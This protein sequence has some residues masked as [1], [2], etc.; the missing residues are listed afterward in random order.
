M[1]HNLK[2]FTIQRLSHKSDFLVAFTILITTWP[3]IFSLFAVVFSDRFVF[4]SF[5]GDETH[6]LA[7]AKQYWLGHSPVSLVSGVNGNQDGFGNAAES[8]FYPLGHIFNHSNRSFAIAAILIALSSTVFAV[9]TFYQLLI[10]LQLSKSLAALGVSLVC[11]FSEF[12][13]SPNTHSDLTFSIARWPAPSLHYVL[14]N[15]VLILLL[16]K[17][18]NKNSLQIGATL[19]VGFYLYFFTWQVILA[20]VF[21]QLLISLYRKEWKYSYNLVLGTLIAVLLASPIILKLARTLQTSTSSVNDFFI[22][23][24]GYRE[25]RVFNL[26]NI[27]ILLGGFIFLSFLARNKQFYS[28]EQKQILNTILLSSLII[29]SQSLITGREIQPGHYYWYFEKPYAILGIYILIARFIRHFESFVLSILIVTL[30][31]ASIAIGYQA[32]E[33]ANKID[34][35]PSIGFLNT[36]GNHAFTFSKSISGYWAVTSSTSPMPILHM[37]YYPDSLTETV[38]FCAAE[39]IW[40]SDINLDGGGLNFESCSVSPQL[41]GFYRDK[42]KFR[43]KVEVAIGGDVSF[44]FQ[45]WLMEYKVDTLVLDS[46]MT[47]MQLKILSDNDFAYIGKHGVLYSIY[48]RSRI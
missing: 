23:T 36:L 32:K 9:I 29:Q 1:A 22:F 14:I 18:S 39:T 38:R 31:L 40:S 24:L 45:S 46:P 37:V 7:R 21:A 3:W 11:I 12:I 48:K 8:I 13:L 30:L 25:I 43:S 20:I 5:G 16:G 15:L 35:L 44:F 34:S 27:T 4:P 17:P 26:A 47:Q 41:I 42:N 19:A 28:K 2:R 10:K 6:Y 33:R